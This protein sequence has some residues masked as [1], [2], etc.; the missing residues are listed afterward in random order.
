MAL[1]ATF[2]SLDISGR[3]QQNKSLSD[4]IDKILSRQGIGW[5]IRK[6]LKVANGTLT[7]RHVTDTNGAE[8][9]FV[10]S[11]VGGG[12]V[13]STEAHLLDWQE[14]MKADGPMGPTIGKGGKV[15]IANITEEYLKEGWAA[16][17]NQGGLFNIFMRSDTVK[18]GK[19]WTKEEIW[20][21]QEIDGV[22]RLVRRIHFIGRKGEKINA[23]VVFDFLGRA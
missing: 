8:Q 3:F 20:G 16:D 9:L 10:E 5:V 21:V 23:S 1:P 7:I 13:G 14:R 22:K 11:S 12:V 4:D 18:T 17:A 19:S 6:A 15:A 2:T